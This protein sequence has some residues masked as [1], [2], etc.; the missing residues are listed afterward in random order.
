VLPV[1][2]N[3][4]VT[5]MVRSA[6]KKQQRKIAKAE[7]LGRTRLDKGGN[8]RARKGNRAAER[9]WDADEAA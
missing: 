6:V 4:V 8:R 2:G 9:R 1:A 5:V 7:A 3:T